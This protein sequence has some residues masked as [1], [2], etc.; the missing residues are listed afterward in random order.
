[1]RKRA[2]YRRAILKTNSTT[3]VVLFKQR[4]VARFVRLAQVVEQRTPRRHQLQQTA[5]RMIV[6]HMRLEVLG[7]VIDAFRQDR[8]LNLGGAGIACLGST[9]LDDSRLALRG[10]R[11]RQTFSLRSELAV[12][13]V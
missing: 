4:L 5:P 13:P 7:E 11:H 2:L 1:M 12:S 6:L 10:N 9:G 8:D 3:N